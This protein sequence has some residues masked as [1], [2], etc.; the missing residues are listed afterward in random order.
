VKKL[1]VILILIIIISNFSSINAENIKFQTALENLLIKFPTILDETARFEA[2]NGIVRPIDA[3]GIYVPCNYRFQDLDGDN[4]PEAIITFGYPESEV[5]FDKVY[6]LYDGSYEQIGQALFTFYKNPQGKLVAATTSG[7]TINA[8]YFAEIQNKKL[9]LND[10]IDSKGNNNFNGIKYDSFSDWN[11]TSLWLATDAD[12]TL[13]LI[14]E[15]DCS[16]IVNAARNRIYNNPKTGDSGII[17]F[18]T[19]IL[20][21]LI[22]FRKKIIVK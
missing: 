16:D 7:Y 12:E 15:I 19:I 22:L 10:F 8:I 21:G 11:G 3:D 6:K 18:T 17:I 1:S 13:Q 2:G 4:I 9:I 5:V 20:S 14:P